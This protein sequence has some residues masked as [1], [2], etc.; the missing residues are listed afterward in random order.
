MYYTFKG[1]IAEINTRTGKSMSGNEWTIHEVILASKE[2]NGNDKHVA[3]S[4]W[5]DKFKEMK[6][7]QGK[8][9]ELDCDI[10]ARNS[11][12]KWYNSITAFRI[13]GTGNVDTSN[14]GID[15]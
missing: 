15:F 6:L 4:I 11:N 7:K 3:I 14:N 13:H 5:D 8:E 9:V 10:D 12:G 1:T 2:Y